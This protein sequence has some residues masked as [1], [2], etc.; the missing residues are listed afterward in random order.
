MVLLTLF[1][2]VALTLT[3]VGVYGVIA[4]SVAEQTREIGIR[5]ALGASRLDVVRL[6]LGGG[7]V[8]VS[9]GVLVGLA[10][11]LAGVRLLQ[12][13]LYGISP[14]DVPTFAA[15]VGVLLLTALAA[16]AVPLARALRV[17]PTVALREE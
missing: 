4:C 6:V 13:S 17:Q 15:A 14:H 8:A 10:A 12:A 5:G 3:A 11:T 9:A 2:A 1:G 7:F 16:H